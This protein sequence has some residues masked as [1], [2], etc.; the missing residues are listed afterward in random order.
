MASRCLGNLAACNLQ[1]GRVSDACEFA[2]LAVSRQDDARNFLRLARAAVAAGEVDE[3]KR[4]LRDARERGG[5]AK[6]LRE[7]QRIL[8]GCSRAS[9][10]TQRRFWQR[11]LHGGESPPGA[12]AEIA[13]RTLAGKLAPGPHLQPSLGS[14]SAREPARAEG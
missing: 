3:A 4:A 13:E 5:S 14:C 9:S 6:D 10:L 12:G 8:A 7:T 1:L 2:R 11:A